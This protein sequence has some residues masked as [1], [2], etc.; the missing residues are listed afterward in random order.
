VIVIILERA[1]EST[2][3]ELTRWLVEIKTGIYLGQV[4]AAVRERLWE[5][6]CGKLGGGAA[7]LAYSTS[8]EA[9]YVLRFWGDPSRTVMDFDGLQLVRIKQE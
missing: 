3:G 8:G 5:G 6:V 2:R 1:P 4:T 9:G 7:T